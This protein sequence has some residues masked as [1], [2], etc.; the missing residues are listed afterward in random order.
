MSL[1]SLRTA[2]A[3]MLSVLLAVA[4][5][6]AV[7]VS[8]AAAASSFGVENFFAGTC[9]EGTA[10]S[11]DAESE[12]SEFF[13]EA[14]GH[15]NLGI[16]D[17][18][19]N[20]EGG[21]PTGNVHN[22]RV[23]L[24]AGLSINPDA[25]AQCPIETFEKDECLPE[26]Q[27]GEDELTIFT[28]TETKL[29]GALAPVYNLE[30]AQG[31][32]AEFG[33]DITISGEHTILEGGVS[34]HSEN[35]ISGQPI[36]TSGDYHE[37][38]NIKEVSDTIPLLESRLIFNGKAGT[39]FLTMPS[40][41]AGKQ[42]TYLE[43]ESYAGEFAKT[44]YT[45]PVGASNC[46]QVKFEP[47][48]QVG[49]STT[50]SDKPAGLGIDVLVPQNED[51]EEINSSTLQDAKIT[52]PEGMTFNPAAANGLEAC[53][54]EQ[55]GKGAAKE[56]ACPSGSQIGTVKI[57]TP[58]LPAG[59]MSGA[60]YVGQP[61]AGKSPSSGE[62]Y[63]IFIAA[64]APR[65]GV[66]VRLIGNVQANETTG[67]LTTIVAENPPIPFSEFIVNL[68]NGA[69]TPLAN[70][71][72]CGPA[73]TLA[74]F[75]PY[76]APTTSVT[77]LLKAPFTID[78]DGKGG[79]CASPLKFEP[80]QSTSVTTSTGGASTAYTLNLVRP[81]GQPYVST[82]ATTLPPG[83]VGKVPSVPRCDAINAAA[84]SCKAETAIGTATVQVGSGEAP[85]VLSGTVYF[86]VGYEGAPYGLSIVVPAEKVGPYDYGKIIT[87][88]KV[89]VN[90]STAQVIVNSKLPTIVGGA[91][92]RLR[93]L[94]VNI[95]HANYLI[96]PTN[97]GVLATSTTLTSTL[98]TTATVST[99]FQATGCESLGFKP[100]FTA[101]S[102]A[103]TSRK[104]GASL[105]TTLT[106][107][108]GQANVK[109]VSVT[110]PKKLPSRL[111]TLKLACPEATFAAN[112]ETCPEGS[113]VGEA[114]AVTPALPGT[115][116]GPAYFVSHGGAAFPDIDVVLKGAGVTVILVG[117][118]NIK[119]GITHTKF[120]TLP[121]VPV[122]S[123]K[124]TLPVG[125]HS[126]LG[127][128][129]SLCSK[130]LTMPTTIVAQNGKQVTQNTKVNVTECPVVVTGHS[131]RRNSAI[132]TV[133]TPS[134]GRL[135]TTGLH[136]RKTVKTIGKAKVAKINANLSARGIQRLARKHKLSTRVM[137]RF[138]P[139]KK[140]NLRPT[141]AYVQVKFK[142]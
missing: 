103:K 115:M 16:T 20:N 18:R 133:R 84:G 126:A 66:D 70:P 78:A 127:A 108:A 90:P 95:N 38:F 107:P 136:L 72:V 62:E 36:A 37:Y 87:R 142:G 12:T 106:M 29:P 88:A 24:P 80:T 23:D 65:Y 9:A 92:I 93:S 119:S 57:E 85:Y 117:N 42:T 21:F 102:S 134:G 105:T 11:C 75:I 13:T 140:P 48:I 6:L 69:H 1:V 138:V 91:P 2:R 46:E 125:P 81:E 94:S 30:P 64:K 120:L 41:C 25:L 122:S 137:V 82:V 135:A 3:V 61:V 31:L 8:P 58:T 50:Q 113:K 45:T 32:P 79:A 17:F 53:S 35:G 96:N 63:R 118:T 33:V 73:T 55:F 49:P 5:A 131:V 26:T 86:T 99:P 60:I 101:G 104:N 7:S 128:N 47:E 139:S 56:V 43:V 100:K 110:L 132:I 74:S 19:F 130:T 68:E 51:A 22:I 76:S 39:G 109:S 27:V 14:A 77:G 123:F 112:P 4:A 44:S 129:G 141:A 28:G 52:L 40:S 124:L 98:N 67:Q 97:C 121:D 71:V 54:E 111:A 89:E 34:W 10:T 15:P 114:K 59:S 116:S 83:L